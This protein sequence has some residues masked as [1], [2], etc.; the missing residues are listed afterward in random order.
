[1]DLK[2]ILAV[3]VGIAIFR[4]VVS[5]LIVRY[6]AWRDG[7]RVPVARRNWRGVYVPD[8]NVKRGERIFWLAYLGIVVLGLSIGWTIMFTTES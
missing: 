5:P 3:T 2:P 8:L 4:G 7:P 6:L 1:M